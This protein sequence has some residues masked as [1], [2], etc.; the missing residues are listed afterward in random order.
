MDITIDMVR[1]Y[2]DQKKWHNIGITYVPTPDGD[3][4]EFRTAYYRAQTVQEAVDWFKQFE[5]I[6]TIITVSL[7]DEEDIVEFIGEIE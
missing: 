5:D 7:F 3:M 6:G 1:D 4:D 2:L